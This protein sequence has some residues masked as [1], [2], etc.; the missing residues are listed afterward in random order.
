MFIDW[1]LIFFL[2][3]L[4]GWENEEFNLNKYEVFKEILVNL[5]EIYNIE[6][7]GKFEQVII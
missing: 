5:F 2:N 7:N 3:Y 1:Y 6:L 4:S